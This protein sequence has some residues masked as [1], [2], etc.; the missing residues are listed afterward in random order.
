MFTL[1]GAKDCK[2]CR[3]AKELL[4]RHNKPCKYIDVMDDI[5]S[6]E[7]L[8][9]RGFKTVPQI[10]YEGKH[11]GGYEDLVKYFDDKGGN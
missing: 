4:L 9:D 1:Y 7:M 2:Y 5:E 11:I 8:V 3:M 6:L 10:F